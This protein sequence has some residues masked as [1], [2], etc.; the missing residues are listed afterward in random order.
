MIYVWAVE[1]D[2]LTK[3]IVPQSNSSS[4]GG[5]VDVFVPWVMTQNPSNHNNHQ[6]Q[7]LQGQPPV[8]QRYY[9]LF[10]KGELATLVR[11]AC[12]ALGLV[13]G[14]PDP[15]SG[16]PGGV[17]ILQDDWE[18]SNHYVELRRWTI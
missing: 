7:Q 15:Q 3:R 18:R 11:E 8:Y 6:D 12:D 17:E 13:V 10:A 4:V 9:H 2:H 5:G 14:P 1:Q 16:V